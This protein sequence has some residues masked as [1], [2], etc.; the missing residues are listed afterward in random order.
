MSVESHCAH[1]VIVEDALGVDEVGESACEE[2]AREF[3]LCSDV[4]AVPVCSSMVAVL[5]VE[6]IFWCR[7]EIVED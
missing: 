1:D 5:G 4:I 3:V 6:E 2:G 7:V